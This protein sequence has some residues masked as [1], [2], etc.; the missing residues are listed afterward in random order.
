MLSTERVTCFTQLFSDPKVDLKPEFVF[1]G[2]VSRT[3]LTLPE[4]V[5]YQW[6][7]KGSYRIEQILEMIKQLPNR[8]NM[9]TEKGYAIYVL[10]D[11]SVYLMPE[12]RQ[13]L[14]KKGYVLV[15]IGGG[16]AGDVQINDTSC[17]H[18]LKK[19]RKFEMILMLKRLNND[20]SKIPSP[21]QYEMMRM[22]LK[23]WELLDIDTDKGSLNSYFSQ[24]PW[25]GQKIIFY[26]INCTLW[27]E[28]K[29]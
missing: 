13:A 10:D 4:G 9:I 3:H 18:N 22:L 27:L 6:A 15:V 14:L 7:P 23:A 20:P 17:H 5:N 24:M 2:K 1:K 28:M 25:T 8:I 19:H 11:Y 26:Q 29:W 12:L 21:S 16:I